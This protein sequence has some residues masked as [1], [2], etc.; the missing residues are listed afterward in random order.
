MLGVELVGGERLLRALSFEGRGE[1]LRG[2]AHGA[3]LE[4]VVLREDLQLFL[5]EV[6]AP[7]VLGQLL[8]DGGELAHG[9]GGLDGAPLGASEALFIEGLDA[10]DAGVDLGR[11]QVALPGLGGVAARGAGRPEG[12]EERRD[13]SKFSIFHRPCSRMSWSVPPDP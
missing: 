10:G 4:L 13:Q 3:H 7:D 5:G 9:L 2:A 12:E 1:V 8:V 11:Q 6:Q